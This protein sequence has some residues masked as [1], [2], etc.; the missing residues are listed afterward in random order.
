MANSLLFL[1]TTPRPLEFAPA[2]QA[3]ASG[4]IYHFGQQSGG[5]LIT[6]FG[7]ELT[8]NSGR[9]Q[10]ACLLACLL[11]NW[12]WTQEFARTI[13]LDKQAQIQIPFELRSGGESCARP[14]SQMDKIR[15]TCVVASKASRC[16][17]NSRG[18]I[19]GQL[20]RTALDCCTNDQCPTG[21]QDSGQTDRQ[22]DRQTGGQSVSS[23]GPT[24][25]R[26]IQFANR[27]AF[28][29]VNHE[30]RIAPQ[31]ARVM[32]V[33]SGPQRPVVS[34]GLEREKSEQQTGEAKEREAK[35]EK[36]TA[37][38]ENKPPPPTTRVVPGD[39]RALRRHKHEES[40]A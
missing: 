2:G 18:L 38:S 24:T 1:A 31:V 4:A 35:G 3:R 25:C 13:G 39:L 30:R 32:I 27:T 40:A 33:R 16:Q 20:E 19:D 7:A 17:R 8:R 23:V 9:T 21:V 37:K 22:T 14:A 6:T 10:T 34:G 36:R 28:A 12:R 29:P 5:Q 11:D 26:R 15:S